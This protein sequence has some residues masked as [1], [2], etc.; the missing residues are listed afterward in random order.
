MYAFP[1]LSFAH[2]GVA[3][4]FLISGFVI[5]F[6]LARLRPRAFC[7]ARF[8]RI[9]P[10]YWFALMV[11]LCAL[12][13]AR[14]KPLWTGWPHILMQAGLVRDLAW[15]RS[16]DGISWTLEV[17]IKF[18]ILCALLGGIIIRG[19]LRA[20]WATL[21]GLA[22]LSMLLGASSVGTGVD[23]ASW[24]FGHPWYGITHAIAMSLH[25]ILFMFIGTLFNCHCRKI[26]SG[27]ALA[28][29]A[30]L[31]FSLF[32]LSWRSNANLKDGHALGE[33]NYLLALLAFTIFYLCRESVRC[34]RILNWLGDISYPL[35]AIHPIVGYGLLYW[36]AISLNMA[37][38][39]ALLIAGAI[40]L[41]LAALVHRVIEA[42]THALGKTLARG[43]EDARGGN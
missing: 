3:L 33:I 21:A 7:I 43:M 31:L 42:P 30:A 16:L 6:S 1:W 15:Q 29:S 11:S 38:W 8:F 41:A 17:E 39:P 13:L 19:R 20:M 25:F 18:Y 26:L 35:Y 36:L 4:F 22:G 24:S 40:V 10:T 12:E 27:R 9:V 28:G 2:F 34:P 5:P 37:P 32:C 23:I 14:Q